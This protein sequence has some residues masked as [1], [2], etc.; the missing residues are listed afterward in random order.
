MGFMKVILLSAAPKNLLHQGSQPHLC[1]Q[2][3]HQVFIRHNLDG[4]TLAGDFRC[5]VFQDFPFFSDFLFVDC[6]GSGT[7]R[8]GQ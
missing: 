6:S 8:E 1:E 2:Q 3:F 5:F 4:K 7:L